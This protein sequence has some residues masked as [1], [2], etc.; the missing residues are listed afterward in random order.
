MKFVIFSSKDGWQWP[1]TS[2]KGVRW[3]LALWHSG[4]KQQKQQVC[5]DSVL[6]N[7]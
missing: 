1:G 6:Q 5:M 4:N 2:D 7:A 3:C